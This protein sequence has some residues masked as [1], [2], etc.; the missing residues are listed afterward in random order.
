MELNKIKAEIIKFYKIGGF[1]IRSEVAL[2]LVDKVKDLS[3]QERREFLN[4]ILGNIQNQNII[5]NSIESEN[6]I[7][8]LRV[9][10]IKFSIITSN[11]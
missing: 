11:L 7:S 9:S 3:N 5:N 2:V 8:A 10:I 6:L 1:Q 4:K